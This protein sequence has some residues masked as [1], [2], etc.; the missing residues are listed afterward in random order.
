MAACKKTD[1]EKCL[2]STCET[3]LFVDFLSLPIRFI[4]CHHLKKPSQYILHAESS[5]AHR[6]RD[7]ICLEEMRRICCDRLVWRSSLW[8][9]SAL[10]FIALRRLAMPRAGISRPLNRRNVLFTKAFDRRPSV[11]RESCALIGALS[12]NA[13]DRD[14]VQTDGG[15]NVAR[16]CG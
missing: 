12:Q 10:C 14:Y 3:K 6:R 8:L 16:R 1:T 5:V 4:K 11:V 7:P 15:S 13:C 9:K 2:L